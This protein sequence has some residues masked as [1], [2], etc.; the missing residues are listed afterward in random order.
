M[1]HSAFP[2][3]HWEF[4]N[5]LDDD[6][7]VTVD[8]A[9]HARAAAAVCLAVGT[10]I[11]AD[12]PGP[13]GSITG[14]KANMNREFDD[15]LQRMMTEYFNEPP[16]HD[17]KMFARRF[18]MPRAVF[19]RIYKDVSAR[20]E[21]VRKFDAL[22]KPGLHPLQRVVAALR[23]ISYGVASDAVDEYVRISESSAHESLAMF[24]RAVCEL[25]GV[26]YGRSLPKTTCAAFSRLMPTVAF[27]A[28][29]VPS[30]ASIGPGRRVRSVLPAI[31]RARRRS[32]L[33]SSKLSH[34]GSAGFGTQRLAPG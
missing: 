15:G 31:L 9:Q 33:S 1:D 32:R 30:I 6:D 19:D 8:S 2:D 4:F 27:Q 23:M 16:T 20:P 13:H 28:A 29:S 26:D 25:Y 18:R 3:E 11:D 10:A 12:G 14:R 5:P 24:C 21:F 34:T 17:D 22:G 7:A